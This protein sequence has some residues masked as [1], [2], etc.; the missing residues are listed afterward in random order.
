MKLRSADSDS[1]IP[2]ALALFAGLF[3]IFNA[4]LN[5]L[6]RLGGGGRRD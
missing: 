3:N 5:L 6:L 1:P 4:V 2:G